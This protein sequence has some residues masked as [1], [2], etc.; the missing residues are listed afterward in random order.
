MKQ[1]DSPLTC[2][3]LIMRDNE[4]KKPKSLVVI[5]LGNHSTGFLNFYEADRSGVQEFIRRVG[6]DF[7]ASS[8]QSMKSFVQLSTWSSGF[9]RYS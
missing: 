9:E 7:L 3:T 6:T 1:L 8:K 5:S 4:E 2:L